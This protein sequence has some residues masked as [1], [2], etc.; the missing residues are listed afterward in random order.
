MKRTLKFGLLFIVVCMVI[1]PLSSCKGK[2]AQKGIEAAGKIIGE[3]SKYGDDIIRGY[4]K[5]NDKN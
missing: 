3:G 2:A 5:L 4:D 1:M